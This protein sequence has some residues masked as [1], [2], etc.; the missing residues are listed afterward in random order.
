MSNRTRVRTWIQ[1]LG[2]KDH[3]AF[4]G[5]DEL[6]MLLD[7]YDGNPSHPIQYYFDDRFKGNF[8]ASD[9]KL[10]F[11]AT[12]NLD[13][14]RTSENYPTDEG[15]LRTKDGRFI[16]AST[17]EGKDRTYI[18]T[19]HPLPSTVLDFWKMVLAEKPAA[20]I[21]LNKDDYDQPARKPGEPELVQY[22]PGTSKSGP[23]IDSILL[24]DKES[25]GTVKITVLPEPPTH[26]IEE[27]DKQQQQTQPQP[28]QQTQTQPQQQQLQ[29]PANLQIDA[30][31]NETTAPLTP[32][33]PAKN[34]KQISV[35]NPTSSN[36]LHPTSPPT[37]S[38]LTITSLSPSVSSSLE[39]TITSLQPA[40]TD[41]AP[42]VSA[43]AENST[44]SD[45]TH[46]NETEQKQKSGNNAEPRGINGHQ[47]YKLNNN[48][49]YSRLLVEYQGQQH[50]LWH[51]RCG[52]WKDQDAPDLDLFMDLWSLVQEKLKSHKVNNGE[53]HKIV[54]HCTGGVGRT[55]TFIAVDIAG[56]DLKERQKDGKWDEFSIEKV[57]HFLRK[58]RMNMVG[59]VSQYI[60]CHRAALNLFGG[61]ET[62]AKNPPIEDGTHPVAVLT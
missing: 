2:T 23:F 52:G 44:N 10:C 1:K 47:E 18:A 43:V 8:P 42:P 27:L 29:Q 40:S 12:E 26:D 50:Q 46:K 28:Q 34:S 20:V 5:Q 62:S 60:F 13:R 9:S 19:Q 55:G 4:S 58:K 57:I 33:I 30:T 15:L 38:P 51:I 56:Q 61:L 25:G 35:I 11:T 17:I 22:W 31:N 3:L 32:P 36:S 21:M 6:K 41:V 16:N 48:I 24:E 53:K 14:N 59:S 45:S 54:I 7:L 49:D 39:P 37:S